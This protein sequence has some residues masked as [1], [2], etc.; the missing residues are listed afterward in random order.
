MKK[1]EIYE[2][3][4]LLTILRGGLLAL[5]QPLDEGFYIDDL[6]AVEV[7]EISSMSSFD[8]LNCFRMR[9]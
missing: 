3:L 4:F 9:G 1:K 8:G 6:D 2:F 5:S 7:F